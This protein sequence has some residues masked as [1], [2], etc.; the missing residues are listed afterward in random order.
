MPAFRPI[1]RRN[2][3]KALKA[4]GFTGPHSRKRH[5]YMQRGNQKLTIPNPHQG[6]IGINLL[7][8]ILEEANISREDW[9]DL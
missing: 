7:A 4:F 8:K 6:D 5:Q 9:E 3:I 2:L 1:S